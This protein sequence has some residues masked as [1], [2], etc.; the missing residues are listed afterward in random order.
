MALMRM[1]GTRVYILQLL[2]GISSSSSV[3]FRH[4]VHAILVGA[5]EKLTIGSNL[6]KHPIFSTDGALDHSHFRIGRSRYDQSR[7]YRKD[8]GHALIGQLLFAVTEELLFSLVV[9]RVPVT[10]N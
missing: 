3:D 7:Y 9:R 5:K 2:F 4:T 6:A 8:K 10:I 1:I